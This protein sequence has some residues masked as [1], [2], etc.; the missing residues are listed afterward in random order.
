M[1]ILSQMKYKVRVG[2]AGDELVM[3][4]PFT[5]DVFQVPFVNDDE[6][7]LYVFGYTPMLSST[8][9]TTFTQDFPGS[10]KLMSL[11]VNK[12]MHIGDGGYYKNVNLPLWSEILGEN[13]VVPINK[14]YVGLTYD[15][16]QCDLLTYH[17]S[18]VDT[19]TSKYVLRK[20]KLKILKEGM[21][22]VEAVAF[23][24]GLVQNGFEYRTDYEMFG[25]T[26]P[27][28]IEESFYYGA[29]NCKDRV[30][31]FSWLV[32]N[33]T[34]LE[35]VMLL[36]PNHVACGV[37]FNSNVEGDSFSLKGIDYTMCDPTYIGAPIGA[38]MSKYRSVNP[39]II[40]L[41]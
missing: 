40:E 11:V 10:D 37:A 38:T 35:T 22:D 34:G 32:K 33:I 1:I 18:L 7:E 24:L 3:L 16:P 4:I 39:S 12:Q 21:N 20:V 25:R 13:F 8:T 30:L 9:L 29:N 31:I 36:Y 6:F 23:M 5:D 19:E 27:L 17:N 15:Y 14:P 26:K 41:K 28:F 2:A